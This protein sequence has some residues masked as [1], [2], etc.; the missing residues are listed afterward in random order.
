M[1]YLYKFLLGCFLLQFLSQ[2][3]AVWLTQTNS[4]I[5]LLRVAATEINKPMYIGFNNRLRHGLKNGFTVSG[6]IFLAVRGRDDAE[7]PT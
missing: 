7:G 2:C 1:T 4:C 5:R 3:L 6:L